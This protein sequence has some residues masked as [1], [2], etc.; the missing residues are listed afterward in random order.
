MTSDSSKVTQPL[1]H[2]SDTHIPAN[3]MQD[4]DRTLPINNHT[5]PRPLREAAYHSPLMLSDPLD[6]PT[7]DTKSFDEEDMYGSDSDV[8][9]ISLK[10]PCKAPA[11]D[12]D[13]S[14]VCLN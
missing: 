10:H 8:E 2:T 12:S 1:T 13:A 5:Q 6:S 7:S 14:S 4:E 3:N 11:T 9:T